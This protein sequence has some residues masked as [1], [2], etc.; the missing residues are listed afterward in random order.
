[1]L[2]ALGSSYTL[3]ANEVHPA[4]HFQ[5]C[6]GP[7]FE[8]GVPWMMYVQLD[9]SVAV[10]CSCSESVHLNLVYGLAAAALDGERL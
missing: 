10:W 9:R 8:F 5:F 4:S 7:A 3:W 1:M 6:F 2:C